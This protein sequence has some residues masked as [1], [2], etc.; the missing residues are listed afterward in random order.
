M[1]ASRILQNQT[2]EIKFHSYGEGHWTRRGESWIKT[3][4]LSGWKLKK[5]ASDTSSKKQYSASRTNDEPPKNRMDVVLTK[6]WQWEKREWKCSLNIQ[7]SNQREQE[8]IIEL[9]CTR[10][11]IS[12]ILKLG[13]TGKEL[14]LARITS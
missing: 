5:W 4:S 8:I 11:N 3:S 9:E 2:R 13:R 14:Y 1:K 12:D 7:S 6:T 10:I